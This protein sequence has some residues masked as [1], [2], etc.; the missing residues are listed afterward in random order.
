MHDFILLYAT[1]KGLL[2]TG[3]MKCNCTHLLQMLTQLLMVI[4]SFSDT[5][6]LVKIQTVALYIWK[7]FLYYLNIKFSLPCL[8]YNATLHYIVQS[9]TLVC[10]FTFQ[11]NLLFVHFIARI[12]PHIL[13]SLKYLLYGS[14]YDC[15]VRR[16]NSLLIFGG[17]YWADYHE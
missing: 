5:F 4:K 1:A 2:K 15:Y 3:L 11:L 10:Q 8:T 6:L 12:F 14:C 9:L 17:N 13:F 16:W 7:C